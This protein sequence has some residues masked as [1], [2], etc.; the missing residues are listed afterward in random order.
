[1]K[2]VPGILPSC[3][4]LVAHN[5]AS[6]V[7]I[8]HDY[9]G[10]FA[11][12]AQRKLTMSMDAHVREAEALADHFEGILPNPQWLRNSGHYGLLKAM[13]KYP[14]QFAHIQQHSKKGKRIEDRVREAELLVKRHQGTLPNYQWLISHGHSALIS[15]MRKHPKCFL[16]IPQS[17]RAHKSSVD[18]HVKN[19]ER[20]EKIHHILPNPQWLIQNG[21]LPLVMSMRRYPDHYSHIKQR[22]QQ[23]RQLSDW[24]DLAQRL[25]NENYG[26]LP[27]AQ[28][29]KTNGHDRLYRMI[30][31]HPSLF[32]HLPR[33]HNGII[34]RTRQ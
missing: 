11:H 12:I 32:S 7:R 23:Q 21:H 24:I 5:F 33:I 15:A 26:V 22:K 9:P 20:L 2:K 4:W 27:G 13:R 10:Y 3:T 28:W 14:R 17:T 1:M 8:M 19:A 30:R 16:H 18:D 31:K 25:A 34:E 29:L 6:L